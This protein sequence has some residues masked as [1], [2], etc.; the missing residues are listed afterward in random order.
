M[1]P[2]AV[3]IL[4]IG[5]S[6]TAGFPLYD[7]SY[8]GNPESS[9]E[10]WLE[11]DLKNNFPKFHFKLENQGICGEMT[12]DIFRRLTAI[13][14]LESYNFI[15][16]WGGANDLGLDRPIEGIWNNLKLAWNFCSSYSLKFFF[17]TI[18]PM[19]IPGMNESVAELNQLI[20]DE[21]KTNVIDVNAALSLKNQLN[22]EYGIGDGVHLSISG[23]IEVGRTVYMTLSKFFKP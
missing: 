15:L 22:K 6:H 4:C 19:N 11:K 23:Y 5:N 21:F 18:P 20:I 8:G 9:Y 16:Y 2:K 13:E 12:T 7:P 3:S 17:L 10:Y 1:N 14:S